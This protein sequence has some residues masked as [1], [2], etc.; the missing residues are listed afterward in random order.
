[1]FEDRSAFLEQPVEAEQVHARVRRTRRRRAWVVTSTAVVAAAATAIGIS[2]AG[3]PGAHRSSV[4]GGG[5]DS[6]AATA[7][8]TPTTLENLETVGYTITRGSGGSIEIRV[9]KEMFDA[10]GL[11]ARLRDLGITALPLTAKCP[12][13]DG[14]LDREA[15]GR[16]VEWAG[17]G[18]ERIIRLRPERMKEGYTLVVGAW[19]THFPNGVVAAGLKTAGLRLN[20]GAKTPTC[21]PQPS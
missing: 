21:W 1:M 17:H 8:A 5:T 6:P 15:V 20:P 12:A 4:A 18:Q 16:A 2:T 14:K 10:P 7:T 13:V 11:I 3:G 19:S 9:F